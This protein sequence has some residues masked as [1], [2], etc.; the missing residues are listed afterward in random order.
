MRVRDD[1]PS[2]PGSHTQGRRR[3]KGRRR[4][5]VR[6]AALRCDWWGIYSSLVALPSAANAQAHSEEP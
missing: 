4:F 5:F 1:P 6:D 3:S 2:F